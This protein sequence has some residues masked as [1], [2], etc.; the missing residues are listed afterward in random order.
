M[1][2]NARLFSALGLCAR[3]GRLVTGEDSCERMIRAGKA[4]IVLIEAQASENTRKKFANAC[5]YYRIPCYLVPEG[6]DRAIGKEG[7]KSMAVMDAHFAKMIQQ[8]TI[9]TALDGNTRGGENNGE[10][11]DL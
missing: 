6:A 5:K 4:A 9:L 1:E 8:S 3:A 7:R 10:N 11:Q 2:D